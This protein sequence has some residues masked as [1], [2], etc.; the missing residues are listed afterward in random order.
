[1]REFIGS[2]PFLTGTRNTMYLPVTGI[3]EAAVI[4]PFVALPL[5]ASYR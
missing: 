5:L 1:M 4:V 2:K 3:V